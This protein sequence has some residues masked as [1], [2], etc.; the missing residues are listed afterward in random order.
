MAPGHSPEMFRDRFWIS[1]ILTVP[2][3]IYS[4]MVSDWLNYTPPSFPGSVWLAPILGTIVFFYGGWV[5][6]KSA[7]N[8]IKAKRPGMMTLISLAIITAY[9]YSLA[10]TF[11]ISGSEFFWELAT[12][13]VIML[14]GH[15][16]EMRSVM[17]ARGALEELAKLLPDMV[18]V[19]QDG[20]SKM[21]PLSELKVGS[22]ILVRPGGKVAADAKVVEGESEADESML[23][24]ESKPVYKAVGSKISAGTIISGGSL[25]AEVLKV[26]RETALGGIMRLI[27]SAQ[28]S[29]SKIQDLADRAAFYLTVVAV[30]AGA[31]TILGWLVSGAGLNFALER[32]VTVLVIACPH[33]LGLAVPL[34]TAISTSLSAK[35]GVLVR[36]RKELEAARDIDTVVFDKTGTLTEGK[37]S[38]IGIW[39]TEGITQKELLA[40]AASAEL[41]SEHLI[42][43]SIVKKAKE[44]GV[45]IKKPTEFK[46]LAGRGV[47]A[48]IGGQRIAVGGPKLLAR[49]KVVAPKEIL[50]KIDEQGSPIYVLRDGQV[51]GALNLADSI[52]KESFEAVRE[53]SAL[54]VEVAMLT[55]DATEIAK[56]VAKELGIKTYFAEVLPEEK[57]DKIR[58]LK[59]SGR[60]V[61]MVGDGVNDAPALIEASIGI[62]IGAGT[63]VAIESAGIILVKDD[64]RDVVKVFKL[65][66]ATYKKMIQNLIWATGYNVLAIPLAAGALASIGI[67]LPPAIGALFMSFSTVIVAFNAQLLKKLKV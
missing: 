23:T 59:R 24:G 32:M 26:G 2:I 40:L 11:I 21:V 31:A 3:V 7:L 46:A 8:E 66:K 19:I 5:F 33:A 34:V 15:W 65:S 61:A 28:A 9:L 6:I 48:K 25:K 20:G 52:R 12:L 17:G 63:D 45:E 27:E 57:V 43:K 60:K 29:R 22:M 14:L 30:V 55:G 64:P 35:N 54:G 38:V 10:T 51:I 39:P 18:E 44:E 67:I 42:S 16:I 1:L 53:L 47:S 49:E 56:G 4:P 41:E 50:E 13:I 62:A 37:Q 58:E 36:E